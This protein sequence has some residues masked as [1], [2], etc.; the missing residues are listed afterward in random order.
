MGRLDAGNYWMTL[1]IN[2]PLVRMEENGKAPAR[3]DGTGPGRRGILIRRSVTGQLNTALWPS[4]REVLSMHG[5]KL[6][7]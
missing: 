5:S 4:Y 6:Q 1:Y 2:N 3:R 7:L